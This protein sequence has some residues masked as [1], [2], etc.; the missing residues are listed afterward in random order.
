[1][2]VI[3]TSLLPYTVPLFLDQYGNYVVQCC[4]R[5][6]PYFNDFVFETVLSQ[7][8]NIAQGRF[9]ARAVRACLESHHT[10][11]YQQRVLAAAIA[12][13][14]VQ[15]AM[16]PN[17]ALL[18]TWF[19]DT[20]NFPRRRTILAPFLVSH[21][22]QLCTHKVAYQT[23]LKIVNQR[24]EPEAREIILRSLF[25]SPNDHVLEKILCDQT[26]GITLVFKVLTTPFF[27]ETKRHEIA[28]NVARV[29]TRI[30]A[31]PGQGYKRLMDEVG[32]SS[33]TSQALIGS[34]HAPPTV[35]DHSRPSSQQN[36]VSF[37]CRQ[38]LGRQYSGQFVP[39]VQSPNYDS[40]Q[41][42]AR[43]VSADSVNLAS[44]GLTGLTALTG[45]TGLNGLNGL[46]GNPAYSPSPMQHLSPHQIRYHNFSNSP[47]R[48]SSTFPPGLMTSN[49]TPYATPPSSIESYRP[50]QT[51]GSPLTGPAQM[52]STSTSGQF[53]QQHYNTPMSNN[54][55]GYQPQN[56]FSSHLQAVYGAGRRT[57]VSLLPYGSGPPR[58]S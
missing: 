40:G 57:K 18:L 39:N 23:V 22:V 27:D 12:L 21:L 13:H 16:N 47:Q 26:S 6:G 36:N 46:N 49:C 52:G 5:F 25:F 3:K 56:H 42:L 55:F 44:Y 19:L 9:G 45:L 32:L 28:G 7:M 15:L 8:W 34:D 29:L 33:K 10:T 38:P 51:Y 20:C 2:N 35:G 37:M 14:G 41:G 53:G 43:S 30:K 24:N 17:G 54:L 48:T 1:M 31:Q 11:K 58:C 50:I 4:L